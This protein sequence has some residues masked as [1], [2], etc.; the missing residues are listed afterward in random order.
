MNEQSPNRGVIAGV[1]T[2]R[3]CACCG[4]HEIGVVTDAGDYIPLRPGMQVRIINQTHQ[5]ISQTADEC[6]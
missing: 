1:V 2:A 4:H 5:D 6:V 3:S